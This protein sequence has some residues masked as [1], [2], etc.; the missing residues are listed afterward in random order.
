VV[1]LSCWLRQSSTE[2]SIEAGAAPQLV[3]TVR[4]ISGL[5]KAYI[6]HEVMTTTSLPHFRGGRSRVRFSVRSACSGVHSAA[7]VVLRQL[8]REVQAEQHCGCCCAEAVKVEVQAE[9]HRESFD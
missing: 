4:F 2:A 6:G 9:Q 8:K 3:S 1:L 7:A 5:D